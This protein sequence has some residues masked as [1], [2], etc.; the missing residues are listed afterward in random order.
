MTTYFWGCDPAIVQLQNQLQGLMAQTRG[1]STA[2]ASRSLQRVSVYT[3]GLT[4][5]VFSHAGAG[6]RA[7]RGTVAAQVWAELKLGVSLDQGAFQHS[8]WRQKRWLFFFTTD[9]FVPLC[10]LCRAEWDLFF[11]TVSLFWFGSTPPRLL[12][13][14]FLSNDWVRDICQGIFFSLTRLLSDSH[15]AVWRLVQR[16]D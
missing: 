8:F 4:E 1:W 5:H 6:R 10:G 13:T 7:G 15:A 11:L 9:I 2:E 14:Y 16:A 3:L 12:D